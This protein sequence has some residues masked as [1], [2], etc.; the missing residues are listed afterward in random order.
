MRFIEKT[1][2]ASIH[3]SSLA[4]RHWDCTT[5]CLGETNPQGLQRSA[6]TV[7]LCKNGFCFTKVVAMKQ[8]ERSFQPSPT[9][10]SKAFRSWAAIRVSSWFLGLSLVLSGWNCEKEW[11]CDL[12][13]VISDCPDSISHSGCKSPGISCHAS[14]SFIS[15]FWSLT[16]TM[17]N[18]LHPNILV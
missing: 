15:R 12:L 18:N 10:K 4:R 8:G 7:W 11:I 3:T 17:S 5:S 6:M 1:I 16:L 14:C 9:S 2:Q 13:D